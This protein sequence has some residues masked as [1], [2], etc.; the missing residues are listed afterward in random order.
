MLNLG[1]LVLS[2][3]VALL[4]LLPCG[5]AAWM[6]LVSIPFGFVQVFVVG[7]A[8]FMGITADAVRLSQTIGMIASWLFGIGMYWFA[9][10]HACD[11]FS[12]Y[13]C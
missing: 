9:F 8:T 1:G 4:S 13:V 5:F 3:V 10:W 11:A 2:I 12:R 6:I 7:A